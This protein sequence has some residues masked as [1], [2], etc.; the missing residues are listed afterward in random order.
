MKYVIVETL[1]AYV[2]N[3]TFEEL[4][5]VMDNHKDYGICSPIQLDGYGC[6]LEESFVYRLIDTFKNNA[7][8]LSDSLVP[9][10][11]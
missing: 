8:L 2:Y 1:T 3:S 9:N 6:K 11:K 4:I 5:R 7:A 10:K